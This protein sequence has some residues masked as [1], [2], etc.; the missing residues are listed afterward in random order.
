MAE[1]E[2]LKVAQE[3][4][5]SAGQVL[6]RYKN[7]KLFTNKSDGMGDIVTKADIKVEEVIINILTKTFPGHNIISEER[8]E[9]DR[10]SEFTWVIDPIDGTLS[11]IAGMPYYAI[12]IGLL[13]ARQPYLGV[14]N[15]P[16]E[17]ELYWAQKGE[18][19]FMNG[20]RIHVSQEPKLENS[21]FGFDYGYKGRKD[22]AENWVLPVVD[23][24]RYLYTLGGT[25]AT[26]ALVAKGTLD[27]YFHR[28]LIWDF[29]A[30]VLIVEEAGGKVTDFSGGPL[31]W[32]NKWLNV[33]AT[34]GLVHD[35]V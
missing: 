12:S 6:G 17:K 22:E 16:S 26:M 25:V 19:A 34:N 28:A 30:G 7:D 23:N 15:R 31:D 18:G 35:P 33:L 2:F 9:I 20:T 29:A 3:A 10:E 32:S 24:V 27:G 13:K 11:F 5:M 4:A 1:S 21:V 8:G 14:I